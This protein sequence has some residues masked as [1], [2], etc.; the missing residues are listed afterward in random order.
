MASL[1]LLLSQL[2]GNILGLLVVVRLTQ[3]ETLLNMLLKKGEN[4]SVLGFLDFTST[5]SQ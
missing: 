2:E 1:T 3:S 5:T 4:P